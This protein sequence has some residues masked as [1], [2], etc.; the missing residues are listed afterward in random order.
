[1]SNEDVLI[2]SIGVVR[3]FLIIFSLLVYTTNLNLYITM[4]AIISFLFIIAYHRN[5]I[6]EIINSI[7]LIAIID[8]AHQLNEYLINVQNSSSIIII[9]S[10]LIA[11]TVL[12]TVYLFLKELEE[13]AANHQNINE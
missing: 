8:F 9:K 11:F 7:S 2:I 6:Y 3:T 4:I 12:Y 5:P 1:M 10:I 13:I